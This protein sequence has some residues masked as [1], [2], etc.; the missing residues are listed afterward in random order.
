MDGLDVQSRAVLRRIDRKAVTSL[1]MGDEVFA[2]HRLT[3]FRPAK[4]QYPP[5]DRG[6]TEV[7][8]EAHHPERLSLRDVERL[9]HQRDGLLVDIA[10][11]MLEIVQDR[12]RR[13]WRRSPAFYQCSRQPC[14]EGRFRGHGDPPKDTRK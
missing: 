8:I 1:K 2:P 3:G 11:L 9:G 13:P 10:E 4:L 5:L 7:V 14:L 12:Q 6:T